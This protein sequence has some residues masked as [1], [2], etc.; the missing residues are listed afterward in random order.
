MK[1]PVLLAADGAEW[2]AA[3]GRRARARRPPRSTSCAAASTSS[4]CSPSPRPARAGPRW[5]PPACAA[6]TPTPS[7][8]CSP[9]GVVPSGVVPRG[10]A[11]AEDRLRALG[12]EHRRARR[13]RRRGRRRRCSS[14]AV[15][16]AGRAAD[17]DRPA[18]R[19]FGD[20]ATSMADRRPAP[21]AA[22][23]RR[24]ARPARLGRSRSGADR[25]ARAARRSRSRWPTSS[26]GSGAR[27]CWSTPTSTAASSPPCSGCST[28]RRAWPRPAG[29]PRRSAW[30]PPRWP[31]CAGSSARSCGCSPASRWPTAGPSCARRRSTRCWRARA[32]AGRL[33]RRRLRVLPRDR[34]GAVLRHARAATQRRDPGGARRRRPGP[35]RRRGRPDRHAAAGPR[36]G[37]AARRRGRGADLGGAEPG[38]PRASCPAT[39]RPS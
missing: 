24:R 39:R 38:A 6:S 12:V 19:R 26:P 20:P 4:T 9:R 33:H 7:T 15:R 11:A 29:R 37:R 1:L 8:G 35:R 13:R 36:A 32:A 5:S 27:A 22:G 18:T 34:R 21:G 2:E 30:T 23:R 31:G 3:A 25:R 16:A 17:A 28:S 10:D 14:E